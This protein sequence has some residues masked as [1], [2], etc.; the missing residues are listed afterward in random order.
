M[1]VLK[2]ISDP[3]MLDRRAAGN[4]NAETPDEEI[5][6]GAARIHIHHFD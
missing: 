6:K 1:P 2:P 3:Q 4:I 5:K